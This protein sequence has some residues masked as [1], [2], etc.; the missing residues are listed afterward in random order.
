MGEP[1]WRRLHPATVALEFLRVLGRLA[2]G[3]VIVVVIT[4]TRRGAEGLDTLAILFGLFAVVTALVRF[5]TFKFAVHEGKLLVHSG[6]FT[7]NERT[8]PL[9]RIQHISASRDLLHR[10]LGLVKLKVETASGT[11]AEADIDA[12]AEADAV[13]LTAELTGRPVEYASARPVWEREPDRAY[14][15]SV[16]SLV[17]LGATGNRVL[18]LVSSVVGFAFFLGAQDQVADQAMEWFDATDPRTLAVIGV[19]VLAVGWGASVVTTLVRF[20]DFTV[21]QQGTRLLM[22]YGLVNH[23]ERAVELGRVQVVEAR[24]SVGQRLLGLWGVG[25][26]TAGGRMGDEEAGATGATTLAPAVW[27]PALE[28]TV[29]LAVPGYS[30]SQLEW[31]RLP[32]STVARSV[33]ASLLVAVS[34][35]AV[36][37]SFLGPVGWALTPAILLVAGTSGWLRFR[38]FRFADAGE[39]V[40]VRSGWLGRRLAVLPVAKLQAV[41]VERSPAQKFWGLAGVGLAFAGGTMGE[42]SSQVPDLALADALALAEDLYGRSTVLGALRTDGL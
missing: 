31:R 20:W 18:A 35:G 40:A 15:A 32:W 2:W 22:A 34:I 9:D 36:G 27:G 21:R 30:E 12:L 17:A 8:I 24:Q 41:T 1:N 25:L 42:A 28:G 19:A 3:I 14:R 7:K 37:F 23:Q 16:G 10:A 4:V 11:G 26:H 38:T 6:L 39:W 13:A 5:L 33:H 29:G